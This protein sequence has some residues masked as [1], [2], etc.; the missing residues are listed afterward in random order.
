MTRLV[1]IRHAE[2][3]ASMSGRIYG[4]CEPAL[5][6]AGREHAQKLAAWLRPVELD[7]VHSSPSRRAQETAAPLALERQLKVV[8]HPG[9]M[10]IDFGGWEGRTFEELERDDPNLYRSWMT[11]PTQTRFPGGES[12]RELKTRVLATLREIRLDGSAA[13]LVAHGGV[14]RVILADA[15]GVADE[16]IFRIDQPLGA[17]SVVDWVDGVP[18]VRA[19]N[20]TVESAGWFARTSSPSGTRSSPAT[21]RTRTPRGW[22]GGWPDSASTSG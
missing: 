5:S 7:A 18:I 4:T 16:H 2:V 21:P 10:D 8:L 15:L 14:N 12:F 22:P 6:P 11:R 20:S 17:V 13:A 9:L 3:E 19:V 1:I